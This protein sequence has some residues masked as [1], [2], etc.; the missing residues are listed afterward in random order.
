MSV[1]NLL[2]QDANFVRLTEIFNDHGKTM[3]LTELFDA[4]SSRF[5][6]LHIKLPTPDGDILVDY[7]K[8]LI[9]D[10]ILKSLFALVCAFQ[11]GI[12]VDYNCTFQARS[13]EVEKFRDSMFAGA[14]INFTEN[15][16]VLHVA[17]RNR[18]NTPMLV[19]GKDVSCARRAAR[20]RAPTI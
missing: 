3:R 7:S 1:E 6:Q 11:D 19:D 9:D 12:F 14:P 4:D 18:A 5:D 17:L 8:N 2:T 13:R 15:R 16:A 20:R 10:R